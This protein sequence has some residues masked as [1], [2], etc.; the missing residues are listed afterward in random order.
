MCD[1]TARQR[2][3][4][5]LAEN[6]CAIPDDADTAALIRLTLESDSVPEAVSGM[7]SALFDAAVLTSV[8]DVPQDG[9]KSL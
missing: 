8:D 2:I 5:L 6:D 1:D 9:A 4:L 3:I 7:L